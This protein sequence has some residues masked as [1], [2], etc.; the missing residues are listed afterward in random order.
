MDKKI[1]TAIDANINRAMEGV[2]VCEDIL[3]FSVNSENSVKFKELRHM[4]GGF[5]KRFSKSMLLHGRDVD[6][7]EQKF[8]DLASEKERGSVS[9]LFGANIHRAIEAVRSIE[10][11]SKLVD[12]K[13]G[14]QSSSFQEI[15]FNLYNLEKEIMPGLMK[16]EK[17]SAFENSLYSL[18][19]S[20]FVKNNDYIG[21]ALRLIEGGASVI[22]LR[23]KNFPPKEVL[24]AAGDVADLC[25][26]KKVIFIINDHPDI[27][28]LVNADGLHLGQDDIPIA[29][30]RRFLPDDN[31]I[32]ISTHSYEQAMAVR[33]QS[34]DYIAIGPVFDTK[35]KTGE[36]IEGIGTSIVN[37]IK[38]DIDIPLVAIGGI[39]SD[40]VSDVVGAGCSC[41]AVISDLYRDDNIEANS[42]KILQEIIK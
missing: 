35:S 40:N 36:L 21:T 9:D 41:I 30:A 13:N 26:E 3:R 25:R 34:P 24:S 33:G 27:A 15:R 23:M 39:T 31:I 2:R 20:S 22:Q 42:R 8:L 19:D 12:Y 16:K 1:Y 6:N 5:S 38:K 17:L 37:E 7:D 28:Y 14:G 29:E 11:F 18:L 4:I 32:G 10:E